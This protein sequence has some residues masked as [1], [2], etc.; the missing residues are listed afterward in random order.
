MN[1]MRKTCAK[2]GVTL[3]LL[4]CLLA[5][6]TGSAF[7]ATAGVTA[8]IEVKQ[9][10][11]V[12]NGY[13]AGAGQEC[14]YKFWSLDPANPMPSGLNANG[15]LEFTLDGN[16]SKTISI[17]FTHAGE[18]HYM[19]K[20]AVVKAYEN[21]Y[22]DESVYSVDVYVENAGEGLKASVVVTDK[23]GAKYGE[24][25]YNH[26][27]WVHSVPKTGDDNSAALWFG[28]AALCLSASAAA[29]FTLCRRKKNY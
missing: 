11:Q 14:P 20:S 18:Y 25:C 7:A 24:I 15:E 12:Q 10:F 9:V 26:F 6:M 19:V 3:L 22:Y 29:A 8:T 13:T 5:A 2:L 17:D 28:V 16:A 4:A 21:Y 27:Y 1:N 23:R